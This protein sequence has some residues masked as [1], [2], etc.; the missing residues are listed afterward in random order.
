MLTG[1]SHG[2][3]GGGGWWPSLRV[4]VRSPD[5]QA[6]ERHAPTPASTG[7]RWSRT[8]PE[9][10]VPSPAASSHWSGPCGIAGDKQ[11]LVMTSWL[12]FFQF[13]THI[14]NQLRF[15]LGRI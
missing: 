12:N 10:A 9:W 8:R 2:N 1:E 11:V 14:S 13:Y 6:P 4:R 3:H 5:W 7:P 15:R